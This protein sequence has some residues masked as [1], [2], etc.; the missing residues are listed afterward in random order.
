VPEQQEQVSVV[1][2]PTPE[3]PDFHLQRLLTPKELEQPWFRTFF[4]NIKEAI[5]PPKLPPLVLTSK[6][7]E[8]KELKIYA[9]NEA[10]AGISSVLIHVGVLALMVF[11]GSLKPVQDT[12]KEAVTLIAPNI[13]EYLAPAKKQA[14]GGG[15]GGARAPLDA[16]K[17]KLPKLAPKQFT[18]PRV[19]PIPDPKLPMVPTIVAQEAPQIEAN[20]Y[21]DPLSRLGIPSNGI[22]GG[23]GIG[24][25]SGG[26]VGSG[27]GAGVGPGSGGGFGGGVYRIGGGVSAPSVLLKVE[28]EYS[29]EARKAKWQGTV[30]LSLVVDDMGRPQSLK[31]VRSL[32]LGLDQKAIDAVE[33][34]RFKP[35]MKDGKAVAVQATIEVNFRLL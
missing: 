11:I 33:K 10:K 2:T 12:V 1:E 8:L 32:G 23:G 28:P 14:G 24:N 20:N 29:E 21:G 34:W 27:K 30:V 4:K 22:G 17:G 16:S 18:P 19:D 25:G 5:H 3:N 13:S 9:G 26:G 31:V 7:V 15:G 6:P 35:G